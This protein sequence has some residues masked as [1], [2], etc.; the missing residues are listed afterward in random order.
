MKSMVSDLRIGQKVWA[1]VEE[2]LAGNELLINF[3]GDLVR[4]QNQSSKLFKSGSRVQM[5]VRSL[6]PLTFRVLDLG[7]KYSL[8]IDYQI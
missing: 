5:E 8:G 7:R 2:T 3:N 4:V 6:A 1:V